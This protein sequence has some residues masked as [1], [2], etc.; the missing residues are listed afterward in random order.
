VRQGNPSDSSLV[1][2][3]RPVG[4]G[5]CRALP[6][7][8]TTPRQVGRF[9]WPTE[10][11]TPKRERLELDGRRSMNPG[12]LSPVGWGPGTTRTAVR[13]PAGPQ[14]AVEAGAMVQVT[15]DFLRAPCA[16]REG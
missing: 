15:D 9:S 12:A 6:G 16:V 8:R 10:L 13:A 3:L 1:E 7:G 5:C 11:L 4:A 2:P 14:P